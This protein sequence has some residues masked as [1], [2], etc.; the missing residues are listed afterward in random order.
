MVYGFVRQS[1]GHIRIDSAIG[2]GTS[3][4]LYL[5]RTLDPVVETPAGAAH[6]PAGRERVL[7]VEDNDEV[8]HAV[9]DMLT[10]WGYR[11]V[12]AENP[13]VAAA[14]L[15][16]DAVFDLLFTDVVMPGS[17]SAIELA[18]LAQRRRPEIAVLLTSGYARD[19][20]PMEDRPDYPMIT[21]PYRGEELMARLRSVLAARR[22]PPP[23]EPAKPPETAENEA[24]PGRPR[25]VLLVEDEVVLRMST[26]DMLEQLGCFVAGVGS[27]EQALELLARGGS[28]DLLL[29][30]LGLPGISGEELA[31]RVRGQFPTLPVV[32]ASGYGRSGIQGE[33][34]QFISKPY[35]AVDLQQALDHAGRMAAPS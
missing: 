24:P 23:V 17:L 35:S 21:K 14:I 6:A 3:V 10:G 25:R 32:I 19:L 18:A 2:Q 16:R 26:T 9:V 28:F 33:G 1:N 20:I 34:L 5:P 13:D 30:D 31:A 12:A 11:V 27:G 22:P 29:T 4:K 8:R 7:V 15:D